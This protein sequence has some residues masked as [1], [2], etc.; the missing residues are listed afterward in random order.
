MNVVVDPRARGISRGDIFSMRHDF[1]SN[2]MCRDEFKAWVS[3]GP[4]YMKRRQCASHLLE[5]FGLAIYTPPEYLLRHEQ[6][7]FVQE[8]RTMQ[9]G[10]I[11]WCFS[12]ETPLSRSTP[13]GRRQG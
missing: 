8:A 2:K 4:C 13:S 10:R 12:N 9:A 1:E 6:P 3:N 5:T 7:R 11:L